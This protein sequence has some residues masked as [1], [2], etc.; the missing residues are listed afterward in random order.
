ML[1]VGRAQALLESQDA[2][3]AAALLMDAIN[4]DPSNGVAYYHLARAN[5]GLGRQEI[6]SGLLDKAEA[7]LGADEEWQGRIQELRLAIGEAPAKPLGSS[8]IDQEF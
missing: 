3:R 7:L 8:P 1:L 6:A 4:L 2:D 5:E